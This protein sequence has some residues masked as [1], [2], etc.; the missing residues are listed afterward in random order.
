M[1]IIN[2]LFARWEAKL[3]DRAYTK[4]EIQKM[5]EVT[6]DITDKVLILIFSS[7][8]FGLESWDY[9]TCRD[10]IFFKNDDGGY[11]GTSLRIYGEDPKRNNI[12]KIM[13]KKKKS[14][15]LVLPILGTV[16]VGQ[17]IITAFMFFA[18]TNKNIAFFTMNNDRIFDISNWATIV[19]SLIIGGIITVSI[20]I[21]S[22]TLKNKSK[23][24]L[25]EKK[26]YGLHKTQLL[27]TL[28]KKE[29][30]DKNYDSANETFDKIIQTLQIFSESINF[31]ESSEI[32]ELAEIGKLFCRCEGDLTIS[33]ERTL[34]FIT[35][36]PTNKSALFSKF[37]QVLSLIS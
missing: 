8:E 25:D 24:L 14:T 33:T 29:F 36:V 11:K 31:K 2:K 35:S 12:M 23:K 37:E 9:F 32:L 7:G 4:E 6:N 28:A 26:T 13:S 34:P 20:L 18:L 3:K 21:H 27:L 1:E 16:V 15:S 17:A 10:V 30:E 19:I 5:L 22:I